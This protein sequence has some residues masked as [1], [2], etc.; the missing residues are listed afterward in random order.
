[1]P[2]PPPQ[3]LCLPNSPE[4]L[5]VERGGEEEREGRKEGPRQEG[6]GGEG[7]KVPEVGQEE[8]CAPDPSPVP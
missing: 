4:D 1:M 3:E 2:H 6:C 5:R 8:D 7:Q